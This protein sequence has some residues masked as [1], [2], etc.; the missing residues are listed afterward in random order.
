[1]PDIPEGAQRSEDGN[2]WWDGSQWQ[3]VHDQSTTDQGA[4]GTSSLD[5]PVDWNLYPE[6]VRATYYGKDIDAYLTDIGVDPSVITD[7]DAIA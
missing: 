4:P 2:W 1:M 7:D 3:P 5:T 6:L